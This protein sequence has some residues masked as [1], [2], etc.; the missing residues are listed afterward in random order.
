MNNQQLINFYL[1]WVN[2]F[3]TIEGMA[4]HHNINEAHCRRQ[5]EAGRSLYM[6]KIEA[7]KIQ[8]RSV[9]PVYR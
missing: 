6:A 2:D 3:L 9:S 5:I 1:D 8:R 7:E 4:K